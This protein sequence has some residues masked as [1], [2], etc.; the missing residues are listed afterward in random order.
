M[1]HVLYFSLCTFT[2]Y[3][4]SFVFFVIDRSRKQTLLITRFNL[5]F[6]EQRPS[7]TQSNVNA[8][9]AENEEQYTLSNIIYIKFQN[10]FFFKVCFE[11]GASK[12]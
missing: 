12:M 11:G 7:V 1:Y 9:T 10:C 5:L 3:F 8:A 6:I 4:P 2:L